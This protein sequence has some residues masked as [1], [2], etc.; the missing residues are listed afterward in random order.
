MGIPSEVV[1]K[2]T[3]AK[4]PTYQPL[5]CQFKYWMM[6][7]VIAFSFFVSFCQELRGVFF[8][9]LSVIRGEE[10]NYNFMEIALIIY[11]ITTGFEWQCFV[12]F[13]EREEKWKVFLITPIRKDFIF[14]LLNLSCVSSLS[15]SASPPSHDSRTAKKT[16]L[17]F[18]TGVFNIKSLSCFEMFS[19][20][21]QKTYFNFRIRCYQSVF[22]SKFCRMR[23]ARINLSRVISTICFNEFNLI[24]GSGEEQ[25]LQV[26]VY[27][28]IAWLLCQ[29]ICR[30]HIYYEGT[31]ASQR[32]V[33]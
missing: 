8:L 6:W 29:R 24:A 3:K 5:Y 16:F 18:F 2:V 22:S 10:P 1:D 20:F 30:R 27:A 4:G 26:Q 11:L 14:A 31:Y 7:V 32:L 19:S 28:N 25:R 23:V 12:V 17:V 13:G 9:L 15:L 33:C 21:V